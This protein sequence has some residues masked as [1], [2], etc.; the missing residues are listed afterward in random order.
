MQKERIF[1]E[2]DAE[3]YND[4]GVFF[5]SSVK[6]KQ[7]WP[8]IVTNLLYS[9]VRCMPFLCSYIC[10]GLISFLLFGFRFSRIRSRV[11]PLPSTPPLPASSSRS[12][13]NH[14]SR[15]ATINFSMSYHID[16]CR[17]SFN[18]KPM[19]T[20]IFH[21]KCTLSLFFFRFPLGIYARFLKTKTIE[22][23]QHSKTLS[24]QLNSVWIVAAHTQ[25]SMR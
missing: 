4:D 12:T 8:W 11:L 3:D 21:A 2:C 18:T 5:S 16:S 13:L 9:Y 15:F 19:T 1:R 23:V 24:V 22:L 6:Q 17:L 10:I 14:T 7:A 25:T 20:H